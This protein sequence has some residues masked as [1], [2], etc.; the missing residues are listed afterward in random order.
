LNL[1]QVQ[2][3][4]P[5]FVVAQLRLGEPAATGPLLPVPTNLAV[6]FG[7]KPFAVS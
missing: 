7:P 3:G 1:V 5:A 6:D 4:P 2:A